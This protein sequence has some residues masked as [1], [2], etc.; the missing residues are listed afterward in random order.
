[1]ICR[2]SSYT[3]LTQF[4]QFLLWFNCQLTQRSMIFFWTFLAQISRLK[5]FRR[6]N[7]T[8][9]NIIACSL[10]QTLHLT[11]NRAKN[12]FRPDKNL[13][14]RSFTTLIKL[15]S[16]EKYLVS[17]IASMKCWDFSPAVNKWSRA[18]FPS[19]ISATIKQTNHT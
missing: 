13:I 19:K 1:M 3:N 18:N 11:A 17:W 8:G 4:L 15:L 14:F 7:D 16:R 9:Y 10:F 2:L 6:F 5:N 12:T